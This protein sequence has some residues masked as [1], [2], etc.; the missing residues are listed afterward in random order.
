M[1]KLLKANFS[2]LKREWSLW[3]VAGVTLAVAIAK[4]FDSY[5]YLENIVLDDLIFEMIPFIGIMYS[6]FIALYLGKEYG[7]KTM[8]NKLIVGHK[9]ENIYLSNYIVCLVGAL[10]VYSMTFLGSFCVGVPLVGGWQGE[11]STL[12]TYI[13]MG[14][15]FTA[16][17]AS[18]LTMLCM[19]C[20]KH[21][22]SAVLAI[23]L[24]FLLML[25]ASIIYNALGEPE[26]TSEM[27]MTLN[28]IEIGDPVPNPVYV[29]GGQRTVYEFLMQFLPTGQGILM[30]N[31]EV[32]NPVLNIIY[33]I[34][35]TVMVNLCGIIAFK[36]KD[37]K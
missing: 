35:T 14:V 4:I 3:I 5:G 1:N 19:L 29:S 8:R 17:L 13:L 21:A 24:T 32:T 22:L 18:I 2:R 15:F 34:I 10:F 6:L 11:I 26:M 31:D 30:A 27:H 9:R 28:G 16:S 33:S 23:V 37:L 7:D 36:K 20:S 12:I 25:I